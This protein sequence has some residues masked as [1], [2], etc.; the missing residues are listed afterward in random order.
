[1]RYRFSWMMFLLLGA[2]SLWLMPGCVKEE[3]S[4]LTE[5][6]VSRETEDEEEFITIDLMAP[7]GP[8][9]VADGS[10]VAETDAAAET[11]AAAE[12]E[13]ESPADA[14][15]AEAPVYVNAK[16]KNVIL[17]IADGAGFGSFYCAADFLTGSPTG[18]AYQQAPWKMVSMA[19]FHKKSFYD[20]AQDWEDFKE[21]DVPFYEKEPAFIPP[22]SASTGTAMM[23][24]VKT[25]NGRV[26]IGPA[27]ERLETIAEIFTKIGR[28]AGA[29]T[30]FQI[31]SATMAAAAAHDVE[32]KHGQ[33][34]FA[35]MLSDGNLDVIIGAA[36]PEFDDDAQ[37]Q[38]PSFGR[39]G[40]S[41]ELWGKIRAGELPEGWTFVEERAGIREL[42][43]L[44]PNKKGAELPENLLAITQ[45]ANSFQCHRKKGAPFLAASPTLAEAS[46]AALNVL[47]GTKSDGFFLL[48]EGG[49][50]DVANDANDLV[51]C[52]EEMTDFNAAVE[53][54]CRWV[55]TYSSWEETLVIVTADHDNGAIYGPETGSD[56]LPSSAPIYRGK[57][58]L[59]HARYYATDH[60]KQLVPLYAR[61]P[62]AELLEEL[63]VGQDAKM[64]A[65]WN[66]DGRYLDNTSV[67][68]IMMHGIPVK[69]ERKE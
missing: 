60:T 64:G 3:E 15:S 17:M 12:V 48:V 24:G 18:C 8:A 53:A 9:E 34:M 29:V 68:R 43:A 20:P 4:T 49:A 46:L 10:D 30:S 61:G 2:A 23:T 35:E 14:G 47:A 26:G 27:D 22:D 37:P 7:G 51:R 36:H 33:K 54:V 32:R 13:E 11:E 25:R 42:A 62:G 38:A 45:T 41:E 63:I 58:Q 19:T 69:K 21:L 57:G 50:V 6:S 40:P 65:Y 28:R 16:K 59:P 39:Y 56:A 44:T 67:F 52:I 1:M 31:A 66:C 55:E 5:I